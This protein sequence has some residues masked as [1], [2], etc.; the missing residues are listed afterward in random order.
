MHS[1]DLIKI[2]GIINWQAVYTA[3]LFMQAKFPLI[4]NYNNLYLWGAVQP[5]LPEDFDT[6]L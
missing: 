1:L 4:F 6:L 2:L 3:P 5:K